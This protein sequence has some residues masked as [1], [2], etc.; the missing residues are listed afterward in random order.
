MWNRCQ[1]QLL[2]P[3]MHGFDQRCCHNVQSRCL[4]RHQQ[5]NVLKLS[6]FCCHNYITAKGSA[7]NVSIISYFACQVLA[8]GKWWQGYVMII[9]WCSCR[10]VNSSLWYGFT[11]ILCWHTE[12]WIVISFLKAFQPSVV[13]FRNVVEVFVKCC[14]F[15]L[16][17]PA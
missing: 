1:T 3:S 9:R 12:L 16:I 10:Q 15:E 8:W 11:F 5:H 17:I 2:P 14:H 13:Y 6:T 7:Q 4:C